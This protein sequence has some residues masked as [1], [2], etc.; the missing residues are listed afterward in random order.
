M[1]ADAIRAGATLEVVVI[2]P[3]LFAEHL[4]QELDR[5]PDVSHLEVSAKVFETI[6][7][8]DFA[9]GI[10]AVVRQRWNRLEEIRLS[11]ELCWIALDTVQ[12]PSNLG[13]I[14]R[15]S[16]A[17]G[18][19]GVMLI[20]NSADPYY[21]AAVSSSM[22]AVLWQ[23]LVRTTFTEF[24][25]WKQQHGYRLIG[26]SPSALVEY[27]SVTY[28]PPFILLLGNEWF[29]LA[30][31]QQ[32]LCDLVVRIPMVGN[33]RSHNVAIAAGIVL[34]EALRQEA[35]QSCGNFGESFCSEKKVPLGCLDKESV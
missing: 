10:A 2:C 25:E 21:P 3:E 11:D 1:V 29:G 16:D 17:V 22:G 8:G 33:I 6:A 9:D 4:H 35:V 24:A 23:R 15:I 27:R 34:Y 13:T 12:C 5:R 18:G 30:S 19:K 26:T 31:E 28:E 32:F 14:L 7:Q 20:G